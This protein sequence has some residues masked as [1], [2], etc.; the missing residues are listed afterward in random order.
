VEH[1]FGS[2]RAP[3]NGRRGHTGSLANG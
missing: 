2:V 1:V 3:S